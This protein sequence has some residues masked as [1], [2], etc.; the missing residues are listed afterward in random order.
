[1]QVG[2]IEQNDWLRTTSVLQCLSQSRNCMAMHKRAPFKAALVVF[3]KTPPSVTVSE[4]ITRLP[5][6]LCRI[7]PLSPQVELNVRCVWRTGWPIGIPTIEE[8]R[9]WFRSVSVN[10]C[11][12]KYECNTCSERMARHRK[13]RMKRRHSSD[14]YVTLEIWTHADI[15]C[16]LKISQWITTRSS[17]GVSWDI[18]YINCLWN[19]LNYIYMNCKHLYCSVI[20]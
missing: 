11:W 19:T 1:M 7:L 5:F 9:G 17:V 2:S 20:L 12:F 10:E 16:L 3:M 6:L 15:T 4:S 14:S 8:V 18:L 13:T